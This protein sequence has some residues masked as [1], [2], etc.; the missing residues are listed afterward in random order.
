MS[1]KI[2]LKQFKPTAAVKKLSQSCTSSEQL[3]CSHSEE[4]LKNIDNEQIEVKSHR[5]RKTKYNTDEER[6][7][8]R[9]KQQKEYRL[10]KKRELEELKKIAEKKN[11]A[12]D[13]E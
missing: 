1:N 2:D 13:K 9:R 3:R 8:A 6:K 4:D 5:G 10:R 7:E 11:E 12:V